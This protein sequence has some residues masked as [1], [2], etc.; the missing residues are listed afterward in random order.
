MEHP[1]YVVVLFA[2]PTMGG[3]SVSLMSREIVTGGWAPG[4]HVMVPWT[5]QKFAESCSSFEIMSE[6]D[7]CD[8]ESAKNDWG[9]NKQAYERILAPRCGPD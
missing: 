2:Q 6:Q 3:G 1:C 9:T 4:N 8:T 5:S 7:V